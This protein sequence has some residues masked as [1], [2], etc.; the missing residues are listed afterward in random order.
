[1]T[2]YEASPSLSCG[3]CQDRPAPSYQHHY[4]VV[5]VITIISLPMK[6]SASAPRILPLPLPQHAVL[7]AASQA[8]H[9]LPL[10]LLQQ[11]QDGWQ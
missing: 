4:M 11:P 5:I 8:L 1:M 6:I 7:V 10:G 2:L 3:S 9:R